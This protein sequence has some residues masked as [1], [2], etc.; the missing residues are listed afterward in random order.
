MKRLSAIEGEW[1]DRSIELPFEFEGQTYR[2]FQGDTISSALAANGVRMLGRSFKYHRPRGLLSVANHDVN[3]L[4]QVVANGRS[5]PNVRAD[6]TPLV[7]HSSIRAV[8]VVDDLKNDR[9]RYL[10]ALAPFLPV[11]FYYKAFHTRWLF[12]KW[13]RMF[14]R[15][16]GLGSVDFRTPRTFKRKRYEFTDV[17]VIGAGPSG[18]A[19]AVA[20]AEEGCDVVLVDE[21]ARFGGSGHY[22]RAGSRHDTE[23]IEKLISRVSSA[24][25]IRAVSQTFVAGLYADNYAALVGPDGLEKLRAKA[26]IVATGAFE[27]P[28]VFRNNDLPGIM[29][30]GGAQRLMYRYA[31]APGERIFVLTANAHGYAAA[32]DAISC[33]LQVVGIA[34]LRPEAGRLSR[35]LADALE[36]RGVRIRFGTGIAEALA[37]SDGSVRAAKLSKWTDSGIAS[38]EIASVEADSIWMSV[39]FAPAN[40]LLHQI[41]ARM[42]YEGSIEQFVPDSLPEGVF[43]CGKVN[44]VYGFAE[45]LADGE[46]AGRAAA[47]FCSG[48]VSTGASVSIPAAYGAESPSHPWPIAE[49]ARGKNFVDFDE[50]LQ[51]CDLRN[52]AQEGFDSIELLK[53]YTTVGMG[54]S[55]GK[56][57]NMNAVRVLARIRGESIER[58]GTTTARPFTHPVPMAHLAGR[59]FIPRRATPLTQEHERLGAVWMPAGNWQRPEYYARTGIDR[60]TAIE[61]EV[62]AVRERAGIIDV[63][64]LG[65][66]E[67][68]GPDAARFLECVYAGR[69]SNLKLGM[70]RYGIM[71]DEAGVIVDDGVVARLGEER[72]YFTTTTSGS[73]S[74]FRELGRL[75]TQWGFSVGLVNLTGH[76]AAFNLAGPRSRAILR[77]LTALDL[78]QQAFPYLAVREAEVVGVPARI[79]RVG[80]VGE[81]GFEIHV[82]ADSAAGV[83][84]ALCDAGKMSGLRP[85]G[86]EAQ[87]VCGWRRGT[88]LSARIPSG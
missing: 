38:A 82:P 32:L 28:A 40:G 70:T 57:S 69:F 3:A 15:I 64:T 8:N 21:N 74:V 67:V 2:G 25:N 52:A 39:G 12:P 47:A 62:L 87:R 86:V 76:Y 5:V 75:A 84:A 68:H 26:V 45:R 16:A 71:L 85:F 79:L 37:D 23:R 42:R 34:D 13:E 54:P 36:N 33:G 19:A 65:K 50:D 6:V 43:A 81:L 51:L 20:A 24:Q 73:A 49:H 30:A 72:F 77:E 53:R 78:S 9:R 14:R 59:G 27:Q 61:Q 10:N 44:G 22:A 48:R 1:I 88:S 60:A 35:P 17:L 58:I 56:H 11:G 29:L 7:A 18:L 41:G 66:I 83:W 80:F 63:S 46:R 4:M 55:Q 31:V